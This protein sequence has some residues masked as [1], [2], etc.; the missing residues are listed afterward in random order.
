VSL[1]TGAGGAAAALV[2]GARRA[3]VD[4]RR[5]TAPH[6]LAP[7]V[8]IVGLGSM[9]QLDQ[10]AFNVL[11]PDIKNSYHLSLTGVS[12]ITAVSLPVGLLAD[13]PV[14]YYADRVRRMRMMCIG[15]GLFMAF[16]VLTGVAGGL[17]SLALLYLA[18][19]GVAVGAA[20]TSTQNSLLADYYPIEI[21]P[22]VYYA[23]RAAVTAALA[24]GPA[25]VAALTL[26]YDWEIPFLVLAAPTVLF[27]LLGLR[28][29]EPIRGLHERR[30]LGADEATAELEDEPPTFSETFRVLFANRSAR[31]IYY[32]LPFLTASVLGIAQFTSLFY[33]EILHQ[34]ASRR[35][36]IVALATPGEFIGLAAGVVV[37][38]RLMTRNPGHALRLVALIGFGSAA[39][40]VVFALSPTLLWAFGAQFVYLA[41]TASLI[42]GVYA[43]ISLA[44]P[45]RMRTLGFATSSLW[46]ILGVPILP[47]VGLVGDRFGIRAGLL[48]FVPVYVLGALI[49]ASSGNFL[50]GDI[51]KV[52]VSTLA[53]AEVRRARLEGRAKLLMVRALGAGYDGVQVLFGVDLDVEDGEMLAVLGTNGAGKSTLLRAISGLI[54]PDSGAVLFDGR[55]ITSADPNRIAQGGIMHVPGG[56]GVFPGL[57]VAEG[58]RLAGWMYE[59]EPG[60][61][62]AAIERVTGYFPVLRDRWDTP[63]GNLSGGEQQMLSLA[64]AFI[65]KPRLLMIDELSLGLAPSIVDSL[66]DIVR[67]IHENGTTVVLVEQ[68]VSTALRLCERAVFMEKGEVV[69][70]GAASELAGRG[71]LVRAVFLGGA[72]VGKRGDQDGKGRSGDSDGDSDRSARPEASGRPTVA[73]GPSPAGPR[74][75][76]VVLSARALRKRFG[77]I[78]AVDDLDLDLHEGEI[79]GLIGPNGAGKTTAF[80]LISGHVSP[81][82]G[83]VSLFGLDVTDWP[84][85]RRAARGLGRSFQDARLWPGLTVQETLELAVTNRVHTP[86][87]PSSLFCLPTVASA[88]RRVRREA[89]EVIELLGLSDQRDLLTADLSTGQRRLVELAILVAARPRII[90]VDEPSAGIA[91]AETQALVPVLRR[92]KERLDCSVVV[93]EHDTTVM[94]ALAD[95]LVAMDAGSVVAEGDPDDV[96]HHPRVIESFLGTAALST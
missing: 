5:L 38:Q 89:D 83:R 27:V 35:G 42:P 20:F 26:F 61:L 71:D 15:M 64:Q 30:Y 69:F 76:G 52:R 12:F 92:T 21:R 46:F 49:L 95:R 40:M 2:A 32:S 33:Q 94:R 18:R 29:K 16:S 36:L 78:V 9:V 84:A 10:S 54:V 56:R 87:V 44:V 57:T 55:D 66:L 28:T 62:P 19:S 43:V 22:R 90:M 73:A 60:Y 8:V 59:H 86:G 53:R 75:P 65:A 37:V 11:V 96:L 70:S 17:L 3:R 7:L 91:Q 50:N 45:P 39:C 85:H 14:G 41:I 4:P 58:L 93:I 34:D 81:D 48:V 23:Q 67:A 25:I 74:L 79:L 72:V 77:G 63:A 1:T 88:E 47:I 68:S 31:R 80:E 6:R 51:E 24:L 82:A 13:V